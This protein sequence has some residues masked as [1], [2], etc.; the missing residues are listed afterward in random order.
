M[1]IKPVKYHSDNY[2]KLIAE[3]GTVFNLPK[4]LD[5]YGKQILAEGIYND[6]NDLIGSFFLFEGKKLGLKYYITP[7]YSPHIGLFYKNPAESKANRQAFDKEVVTLI[8]DHLVK[9]KPKLLS[10]ALPFSIN[11]TQPFYWND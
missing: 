3:A 8:K 7:P 11:D 10:I 4:W 1:Y 9:L 2:L 6:N 5:I